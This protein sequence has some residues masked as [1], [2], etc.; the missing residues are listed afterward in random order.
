MF[1]S[2]AALLLG[3]C[4]DKDDSPSS[5]PSIPIKTPAVVLIS[6]D[7]GADKLGAIYSIE[8][9]DMSKQNVL[10]EARGGHDPHT[11]ERD[12][13]NGLIYSD[14]STCGNGGGDGKF[15]G[16]VDS[17]YFSAGKL[18]SFDPVTDKLTYE[19]V[20]DKQYLNSEWF[21][22]GWRTAPVIT[23]DC[24]GLILVT[25]Q[26][27]RES[28][29]GGGDGVIVH[30][31]ID[32]NDTENFGQM[33]I[34]YE[35]Y[36][37]D[38]NLNTGI[39]R[40]LF[41]NPVLGQHNNRDALFLMSD[42]E[43]WRD[44]STPTPTIRQVEGYALILSPSLENDWSKPWDLTW[45]KKLIPNQYSL[46]GTSSEPFYDAVAKRFIY[47][48][49]DHRL[50]E[51]IV[52]S[53]DDTFNPNII[54]ESNDECY[55]NA[56]VAKLGAK[57]YQFCRGY[58]RDR[59]NTYA[60]NSPRILEVS[61]SNA[62][63]SVMTFQEWKS[64]NGSDN[65]NIAPFDFTVDPDNGKILV[66]AGTISGA[67]YLGNGGFT[68]FKDEFFYPSRVEEINPG[69]TFVRNVLFEG[70]PEHGEHFVGKPSLGGPNNQYIL[71]FS[72]TGELDV[73]G[74]LLKYDRATQALSSIP[75]GTKD[76]AYLAAKPLLLN[77]SIIVS[78]F[79]IEMFDGFVT[80]TKD[81][82]SYTTQI[83]DRLYDDQNNVGVSGV[84]ATVPLNLEVLDN[85]DIWGVAKD[86]RSGSY[87]YFVNFDSSTGMLTK[88]SYISEAIVNGSPS[89][90]DLDGD[91]TTFTMASVNNIL[92]YPAWKPISK[93]TT[94]A[95]FDV[96]INCNAHPG[97]N[98][99]VHRTS[100]PL[101]ETIV[102]GATLH[103][104]GNLY[105]ATKGTANR[106]LQVDVGTCISSPVLT[107]EVADLS[108]VGTLPATRMLSASDGLLYFGTSD[109]FLATY[110]PS[111]D[112]V[113]AQKDLTD[114]IGLTET[115]VVGF[116]SEPTDGFIMGVAADTIVAN[117]N[118]SA[119]R[120][121]KFDIENNTVTFQDVSDLLI[122][123]EL[124]PG[125][126]RLQ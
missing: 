88:R 3:A 41:S 61:N 45:F 63:T 36:E 93:P 123:D 76:P 68:Q 124:Y 84:Y 111:D 37:G 46:H 34:V 119:R 29:N 4:S 32:K 59:A 79:D 87:D 103:S 19:K 109:G 94:N 6:A 18:I 10:Y 57:T 112:S 7:T 30:I 65:L 8:I 15:W 21:A 80:L 23:P 42:G 108:G 72:V 44:D 78:S 90:N 49:F 81:G 70:K 48:V 121:F 28:L 86:T 50:G 26:G 53:T 113:T 64:I 125:V 13:H 74:Y 40:N 98:N 107:E 92:V 22:Y 122:D 75:L 67:D 47:S 25:K 1:I 71:Q 5:T 33:S 12:F 102:R 54:N 85:G 2:L 106:L 24:K 38:G 60:N 11:N 118:P 51:T 117:G 27:G 95:L 83:T 96:G 89:G 114:S 35:L 14:P 77:D 100:L 62:A 16:M 97:N 82:T 115:R 120:L 69:N 116:L 110:D 66:T 17:H 31:N 55:Y 9:D 91:S 105:V 58:D 126:V 20:I 99:A 101:G 39:F 104:N 56:G 52:S 43:A 73:T